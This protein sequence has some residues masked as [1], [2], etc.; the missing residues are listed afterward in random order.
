MT[1]FKISYYVKYWFTNHVFHV[2]NGRLSHVN[3]FQIWKL[4]FAHG[5]ETYSKTKYHDDKSHGI[6]NFNMYM[7]LGRMGWSLNRTIILG[8]YSLS[9]CRPNPS[10][11]LN[12]LKQH[13]FD[14]IRCPNHISSVLTCC[15]SLHRLPKALVG[16][17]TLCYYMPSMIVSFGSQAM[18]C[19]FK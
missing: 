12:N 16:G 2:W 6:W 4:H 1:W 17:N 10:N 19:S 15:D 13:S 18:R 14:C 11:C 3:K 7:L 8:L 5:I 9:Y